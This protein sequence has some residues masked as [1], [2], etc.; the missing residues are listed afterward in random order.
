MIKK[1][2]VCFASRFTGEKDEKKYDR[3]NSINDGF[4]AV[5]IWRRFI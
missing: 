1:G 4:I 3:N 2:I 5:I